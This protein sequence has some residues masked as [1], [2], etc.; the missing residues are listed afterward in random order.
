[1]KPLLVMEI[2]QS[3]QGEGALVGQ[4]ANF[5]RL[6]GC[7][8]SC[9][10][11]DTAHNEASAV[12][13]NVEE[14]QSQLDKEI[15]LL[16]WTGGEPLL[17]LCST[18]LDCFNRQGY[19]QAVETNGSLPLPEEICFFRHVTCSPKVDNPTLVRNF[20]H[21]VHELRYPIRAGDPMPLPSIFANHYFLS[22]IF[23]GS[24][25]IRANLDHA[26]NLCRKDNQWK[27]SIQIH[28]FLKL[29]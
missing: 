15:H 17:Q 11:C 25:L 21:G 28:K 20:P 14:I 23:D 10:F 5:I 19:F 16:I 6:G 7:N 18:V 8:R 13:L 1:M 12:M 22:P 2:F 26:L 27:L 4:W 3:I 9:S 24:N 29:R